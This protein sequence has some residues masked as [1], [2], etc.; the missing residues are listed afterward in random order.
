MG[1][2]CR[3]AANSG[4]SGQ[5]RRTPKLFTA[6]C[7]G[8]YVCLQ[9]Q[10]PVPPVKVFTGSSRVSTVIYARSGRASVKRRSRSLKKE[11]EKGVVVVP[12]CPPLERPFSFAYSKAK[13]PLDP[14]H[15]AGLRR[16][17]AEQRL[18]GSQLERI[19]YLTAIDPVAIGKTGLDPQWTKSVA[20]SRCQT[21]PP[22]VVPPAE[23][24]MTKCSR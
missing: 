23:M 5:F 16:R 24:R 14:L 20:E 18:A 11:H 19:A 10:R 9:Q 4:P 13:T 15:A 6:T 2:Q 8:C 7:R 17:R 12:A 22:S 3:M 21:L 1:K